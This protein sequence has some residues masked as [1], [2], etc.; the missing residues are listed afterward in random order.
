[1]SKF[2]KMNP[3]RKEESIHEG[4]CLICKH[5]L[6]RGSDI[7]YVSTENMRK[8]MD[9]EEQKLQ[10]WKSMIACFKHQA[11]YNELKK[12]SVKGL[13]RV[14]A[15]YNLFKHHETARYR[16]YQVDDIDPSKIDGKWVLESIEKADKSN[17]H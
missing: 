1:M 13:V 6:P 8:K 16:F 3:E 2:F 9:P 15:F 17:G 7:L 10:D 11:E 5:E 4:E 12:E 14:Q